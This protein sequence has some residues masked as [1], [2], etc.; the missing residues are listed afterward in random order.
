VIVRSSSELTQCYN[1]LAA[2]DLVAAPVLPR[3]ATEAFLIDL[4][5]RGVRCFPSARAR[6]LSRSKTAQAIVFR[7][8][9]LPWTTVIHR[10]PDLMAAMQHY[11]SE[12]IARVVTKKDGKHCGYGVFLWENMEALYNQMALMEAPFPFVLQP[13]V[14][15]LTDVRVI[16]VGD[17]VE[18]YTRENPCSFRK[19]IA[20]GGCGR[21]FRLPPAVVSL[22]RDI[23][24]RGG[25][26][27]AHIDLQLNENGDWYFSEMSLNGGVHGARIRRRD[28][29]RKKQMITNKVVENHAE[30]RMAQSNGI[31]KI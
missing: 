3:W 24:N 29:E 1:D 20:A 22:C 18:A 23:M 14:R 17:F 2:G 16:M 31:Q 12:G 7:N 4:L 28:L 8:W 11:R 15:N 13:F 10:A 21:P 25:F 30:G 19:N 27:W 9:I 26:P 5:E 6:V